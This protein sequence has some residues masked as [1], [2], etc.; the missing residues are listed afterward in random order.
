MS[1]YLRRHAVYLGLVALPFVVYSLYLLVFASPRYVSEAQIIVESDAPG[2]PTGF[3]IGLL[4]LATGGSAED[5]RHVRA[6]ILSAAMLEHL[7]QTLQLRA[8]L[9]DPAHDRFSRLSASASREEFLRYYQEHLDVRIDEESM[10]ITLKVQAFTPEYAQRLAQAM[11][12]RAEQFVNEVS[13]GLAREQLAFIERELDGA[14][15]RLQEAASTLV[16]MQ[17]ENQLL[18]PQIEAESVSRIIAGFQGELAAQR[19]QLK[20]LQAY[21]SPSAPEVVAARK[22]IEAL[23]AQIEQERRRQVGDGK[24]EALN[25]LTV[26]FKTQE[27]TVQIASDLY[28]AGL[29]TLETAK[30]EAARKVKHLVQLSP[31]T[32]PEEAGHPR[33]G[34]GI[35]SALVLLHLL[36]LLGG[37][38]IATVR[39]HRD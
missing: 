14:N 24:R 5:A 39:D 22:R 1:F 29:K 7:D 38:L 9:S 10:L 37:L 21:L 27:T 35:L 20:A 6:F 19:T 18:S 12:A 31:P 15:Q 2:L 4:G 8:H 33:V 34:Y 3:D 36:Y 28:Q 11:L 32:L 23:E 16:R 30:L 13:Q 17:T 26:K 25:E